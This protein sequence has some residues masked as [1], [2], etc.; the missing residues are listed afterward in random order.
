M[1]CATM[2]CR[3]VIYTP[4]S[5][6]PTVSSASPMCGY[7]YDTFSWSSRPMLTIL[8]TA[9][10]WKPAR[11]FSR[12]VAITHVSDPNN[13]AAC[14]T[15]TYSFHTILLSALFIPNIFTIRPHFPCACHILWSTSGQLPSVYDIIYPKYLNDGTAVSSIP[16]TDKTLP[17]RSSVSAKIN[18]CHLLSVQRQ[19]IS[20]VGYYRLSASCGTNISYWLH[21]VWGWFP[22]SRINM[23]SLGCR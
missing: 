23:L 21:K 10:W 14:T 7:T 17:I 18:L 8:R 12:L 6:S 11:V 4:I 2:F 19:H 13:I 9:R 5:S 22:S 16:Y 20:E 3:R 15:T 1:Y